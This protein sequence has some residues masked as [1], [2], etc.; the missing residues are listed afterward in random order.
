M[1]GE[2]TYRVGVDIGGTFTDIVLIGSNGAVL[3]KKIAS[4]VEDYARAIV[5]GL[6]EVFS[7]AG[8]AGSAI[9][10]I[11][12]G[13]TVASNAILE[14]KGARVGL[15]TT[16]GFRDVLEIRT[17][18][19]PRLYDIG[20]TKPAPLVERYLRQVVDERIDHR[21]QVERALD[22]ADAERAVAALLAEKVEAIAV[23]LLNSFVNPSHEL[24]LRDIVRRR[25]P[26]LPLSA[27][28][29]VLPEIKEYE[30]TSTTVIN[31]YVM[32]IVATYLEAMRQ[33]L[34]DAG[35]AARLLLMQSNG[36]LTTDK[37]AV[38]R[39][40]HIIESG[41]AGGVIGAQALALTGGLDRIITFD[42][43]G[44]TA[45][46]SMVEDG[47][48]MRTQEYAVG[49]G[50]MIGSRLLT[51]AG[52]TLKV[53]A[54]DLAEVGAGGGSHVWIDAGGALQVGPESA[55]AAPGPVCYDAGGKI[56][57]V[58]DANVILGYLNP[59]HL[60]GGALRLNADKARSVFAASIAE[61]LGMS[62]EAAAYGAHQ[63]AASNMIRAIKAVS[64][65][66]GRDPREFALFAFGGNGPLFACGMAAALGIG[67]VIVPPAPGLFSSFGL[68]YADIE[69]H[70]A[71]SFRRLLRRADLA[72]IE[73][74]WGELAEQA[75][76]QLAIEGFTGAR[77]RL[78]RSAA[79]HYKGQSFDLV[80][81]VPDGPIDERMV[82]TLEEAFGAE[83][84]RTYG[85]RAG[86]EEPV[87]LVAI[88]VVGQ[89]L[90]EG[91]SVPERMVSSRPEPVPGPPRRVY[92]GERGWIETPVLRRSD[93]ARKRSGPLIVEEYDATCVVP[94]GALAELDRAGCIVIA[95]ET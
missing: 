14:Q 3:T 84:E 28:F 54:I 50:I 80:V 79:L 65:E 37:A 34:D 77:A 20:W 71:R 13:T 73:R 40:M 64:T 8:I 91:P 78:I 48:V 26:G 10:E 9:E 94:P 61:P 47:K 35:I 74:A 31:A 92:F 88:Q 75:S 16:K 46:A 24:M 56:T 5:E 66:R 57:T 45:K 53:P 62:L 90:R 12:H 44:T 52:Y 59:G 51:G 69:H 25:A 86:I 15:I 39:P 4:S 43:G 1:R 11:R 87:E 95:L 23:C 82:A 36:G 68:L 30:R 67:R 55:G 42:M 19:M 18:R 85:H 32:P 27:S 63:I 21:G 72:E 33:R 17:L 60:V 70:Y 89:G 58:T 7:E 6:A 83:H 49:A 22:P 76:R 2:T 38:E 81:P 41:P 93:L 29:E